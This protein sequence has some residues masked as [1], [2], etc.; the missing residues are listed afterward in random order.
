MI[1]LRNV[2]LKAAV[3]L[4]LFLTTLP[5]VAHLLANP[6][7]PNCATRHC[8]EIPFEQHPDYNFRVN[9]Y[10]LILSSPT[11][12][13][14][15]YSEQSAHA[16]CY[17]KKSVQNGIPANEVAGHY[18]RCAEWQSDCP[19]LAPSSGT[20]IRLKLRAPVNENFFTTCQV[21]LDP[22]PDPQPDPDP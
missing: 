2:F 18:H 9:K 8:V 10:C 11:M 19:T 21:I 22:P 4:G 5:I 6:D 3:A 7:E 16:S 20:T 17:G 15:A 13:P 14:R 12:D 1:A